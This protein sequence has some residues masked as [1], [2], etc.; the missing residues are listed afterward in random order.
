[1]ALRGWGGGIEMAACSHLKKVNVHVYERRQDGSFERIS[2]FDSPTPTMR[3]VEVL[4]QG[5]VH[6]DSLLRVC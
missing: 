3:T 6:Y 2:C 4:Y 5:G 1:M